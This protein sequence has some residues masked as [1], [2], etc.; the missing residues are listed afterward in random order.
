MLRMKRG[1][2]FRPRPLWT[3]TTSVALAG[4]GRCALSEGGGD[5]RDTRAHRME[6]TT[7]SSDGGIQVRRAVL[8]EAFL[9]IRPS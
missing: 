6:A 8:A 3:T 2:N 4:G 5:H 7:A 1:E 9:R